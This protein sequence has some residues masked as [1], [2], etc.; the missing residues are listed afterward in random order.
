M[1]A[2][3]ALVAWVSSTGEEGAGGGLYAGPGAG[4]GLSAGPG[5]FA[6]GAAGLGPLPGEDCFWWC[7]ALLWP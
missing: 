1:L 6:F 5:A 2:A 7:G 3:P 4:G